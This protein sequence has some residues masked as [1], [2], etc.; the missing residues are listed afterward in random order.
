M[1]EEVITDADWEPLLNHPGYKMI[2]SWHSSDYSNKDTI[3]L[4]NSFYQITIL[5][6][7]LNYMIELYNAK[8]F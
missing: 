6:S 5:D 1:T 4:S 7:C 8:Y 3:I 2:Q